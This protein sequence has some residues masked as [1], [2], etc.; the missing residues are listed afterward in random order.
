MVICAGGCVM[1][2][3]YEAVVKERDSTK[4]EINA[5]IEEQQMLGRQAS[6]LE[7]SNAEAMR[8]IEVTISTT[9]SAQR[10][11]EAQQRL[12]V[13]QQDKL[14]T[15]IAQLSKEQSVLRKELAVS[16]EN[17]A[18]LKEMVEV[19]QK[20]VLEARSVREGD[21][22]QGRSVGTA[23][24][25]EVPTKSPEMAAESAPVTVPPQ[26][27]P[28]VAPPPVK[29]QPPHPPMKTPGPEDSGWFGAIIDWL[30]S[31]WRSIFS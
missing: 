10:E 29:P 15:Q 19:Y 7:K 2:S 25:L 16:R 3:T 17:T 31:V 28:P 11:I 4:T 24:A 8:T 21:S 27:M 26:E 22:S 12:A 30:L 14:R 5:V 6:E 18:A 9:V 23:A 13:V 1:Q 20:K